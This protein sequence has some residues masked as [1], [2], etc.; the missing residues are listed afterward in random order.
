M[1]RKGGR[2]SR[3]QQLAGKFKV[4]HQ[5]IPQSPQNGRLARVVLP[6]KDIYL[7]V[8]LKGDVVK[9]ADVGQFQ[10]G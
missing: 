3:P 9:G 2:F 6:G 1:N 8:E 10:S 4:G 7:A 5:N